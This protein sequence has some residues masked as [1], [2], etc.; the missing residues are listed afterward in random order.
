MQQCTK[1]SSGLSKWL[2]QLTSRTHRYVAGVALAN[3][4]RTKFALTEE[5]R[6]SG[7]AVPSDER[8]LIG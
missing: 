5:Y 3:K 4:N 7:F 8:P 2:A 6:H 1:Q